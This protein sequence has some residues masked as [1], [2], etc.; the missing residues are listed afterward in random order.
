[1]FDFPMIGA[2]PD[3]AATDAIV[4]PLHDIGVDIEPATLR[5]PLDETQGYPY[6]LQEWG[7]HSWDVA[8]RL[9]RWPV[10]RSA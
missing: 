2:L 7:K 5:R 6:F 10:Y 1:M 9:N 4:K 8:E 3:E